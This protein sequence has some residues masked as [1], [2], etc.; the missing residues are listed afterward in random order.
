MGP[1]ACACHTVWV[2][3]MPGCHPGAAFRDLHANKK[4]SVPS[5]QTGASEAGT[6][7]IPFPETLLSRPPDRHHEMHKLTAPSCWAA[8]ACGESRKSSCHPGCS[9]KATA[10]FLCWCPII[11]NARHLDGLGGFRLGSWCTL[12]TKLA[13]AVF[14]QIICVQ[15]KHLEKAKAPGSD[16]QCFF[17]L[18]KQN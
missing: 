15:S 12:A 5:M 8:A 1:A 2:L 7:S 9:D 10:S 13:V 14:M 11:A 17:P 16:S 18:M 4:C 3:G 6:C